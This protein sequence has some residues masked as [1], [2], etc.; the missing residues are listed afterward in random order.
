M[1]LNGTK[2][3]HAKVIKVCS[4]QALPVFVVVMAYSKL[5]VVF[6][7]NEDTKH[8]HFGMVKNDA[9]GYTD[10]SELQ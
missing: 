1:M 7:Y 9:E 4:A 2:M 6:L 8:G 5:F 10:W 3:T